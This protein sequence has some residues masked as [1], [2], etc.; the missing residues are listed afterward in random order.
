MKKAVS[1]YETSFRKNRVSVASQT[2]PSL[3][4]LPIRNLANGNEDGYYISQAALANGKKDAILHFVDPRW[5][6]T[7]T[8]L[9]ATAQS[10]RL[11]FARAGVTSRPIYWWTHLT[12][13]LTVRDKLIS[14]IQI[15]GS[16]HARGKRGVAR[17][18]QPVADLLPLPPLIMV[19]GGDMPT[20]ISPARSGMVR[21]K[22]KR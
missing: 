22:S 7:K 19:H 20:P 4:P 9:R 6:E 5:P 11:L 3:L 1:F 15:Y 13:T 18:E 10:I 16:A 14:T 21:I 8:C 12:L 2:P 17:P